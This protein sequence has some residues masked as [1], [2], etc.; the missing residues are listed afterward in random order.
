MTTVRPMLAS[1]VALTIV[2]AAC[3]SGGSKTG[4]PTPGTSA[5]GGA[6]T[7]SEGNCGG[8][9]EQAAGQTQ[10]AADGQLAPA[11]FDGLPQQGET[12]GN[13][14]A[15][16][17]IDLYENFLCPHCH[18]FAVDMLPRL[19]RDYVRPGK[20][21]VRFHDVALGPPAAQLAHEAGQCAA[22]QGK[23]WPAY[24]ALYTHFSDDEGAYTKANIETWLT[25]AA[26]DRT[27]FDSCLTSGKHAQDVQ[28]STAAFQHLG[29][30]DAGYRDA[31]ATVEA[32]QGPAIPLIDVAGTY[33]TA[34][35]SYD[36]VRAAIDVELAR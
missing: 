27:A 26:V 30:N 1:L 14:D 29:D 13:P 15:V 10:V 21:S 18:D 35:Q 7:A 25:D 23:F 32:T 31:L 19:I 24:E 6:V 4:T 20:A 5:C 3:G 17:T 11:S 2:C 12:L 9:T 36:V 28:A 8:A 33:I 16:V 34:P 22:D